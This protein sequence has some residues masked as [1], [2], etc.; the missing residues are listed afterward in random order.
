MNAKLKKNNQLKKINPYAGGIDVGS[1]KIFVSVPDQP[2]K[3][4]DTYTASL[5]K[6][7]RYLKENKVETVAMEATGVYWIPI[8]EILEA[9][10]IE[11]CLVNGSHVKN[12]P[13]RK[14]DVQD[15]Q[16]LH[17]LHSYGLLR[18]S[19]IPE[20]GIRCLRSYVRLRDDHIQM[21]ASHVLHMQK[22]MD[23]MNIKLHN[24]ISQVTGKSGLR[25]INAILNGVRDAEKLVELCDTQILNKKKEQVILSLQGNYKQEHLFALKQA[26]NC[27]DFYNQQILDCDHQI[28]EVL[29]KMTENKQTPL[30]IKAP[31]L[32]RHHKP[33]V[34]NLHLKLM[35]LTD[36]KDAS[37]IAGFTDLSLLQ[38]IS[39]VGLDVSKW[40]TSKHF[41]SWLGLSPGM[42]QSGKRRKKRSSKAKPKAGQIFRLAAQ[43]VGKSKHLALGGFHRR[44]KSRHGAKIATKATARKIAV[45]YYNTMKHGIEYVEEGLKMYD[46]KY[47]ERQIKY[48]T[49]KAQE[50]GLELKMAS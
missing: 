31:K 16:W 6:C 39:E 35:K 21:A 32:I 47:R 22:A 25:I 7:S 1:E 50:L 34:N 14:S 28:E 40:L 13:G 8:Y 27:W 11:V 36:G 41:T 17:E 12:V 45:L 49:K 43:S 23:L 29:N 48:I 20:E 24:V 9:A 37:Q 46:E 10:G 5:I 4:F 3:N 26:L 30:N 33:E 44:I 38:I 19:F 18:S 2:V 42:H 15:C